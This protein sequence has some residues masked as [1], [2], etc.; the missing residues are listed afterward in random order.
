MPYFSERGRKSPAGAGPSELDG[1][2]LL[3][4][5]LHSALAFLGGKLL[6]DLRM[7]G[8]DQE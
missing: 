4:H 1:G 6:G 7:D 8:F 3:D 5:A 2:S